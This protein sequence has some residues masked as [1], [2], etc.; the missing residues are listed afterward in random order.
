[1]QVL[2][3]QGRHTTDNFYSKTVVD[4]LNHNPALQSFYS[5]PSTQ[6][7]YSQ[8]IAARKFSAEQRQLLVNVLQQQY[9]SLLQP[10]SPVTKKIQALASPNTYTVT[11]G[12]QIHIYLGP[13]YVVNKILSTIARCNWL[14]QQHPDKTFVPVFW[15][16]TED[17]DFDEISH[18]QLYYK[19][20]HWPQQPNYTGA[21]GR[22]APQ[23][24]NNLEA[25]I[26]EVLNNDEEAKALLDL[27]TEAYT[28]YNTLA[29]AT[30][31]VVHTFF[32]AQGVVVIDADDTQLKQ[33]L[34]PYIHRDVFEGI[35]NK[36]VLET[37]ERLNQEYKAQIHPRE[38]NF[39]YLTQNGRYR[40]AYEDGVYKALDSDITFTKEQIEAEINQHPEN[41]SPNVVMRPMYQELILPNISYIGG[42]AEVNYWLQ[43]KDAFEANQVQFPIIELRKSVIIL[44]P[45]IAEKIQSMGFTVED[46]LLDGKELE[47]RYVEQNSSGAPDYSA[48]YK[49]V[50]EKLEIIKNKALEADNSLKPFLEGEFKKITETFEKLDAKLDKN[51]KRK[52]ENQLKQ[53]E[54]IKTKFFT[55]GQLAERADTILSAPFIGNQQTIDKLVNIFN[56]Q[57][58][59]LIIVIPPLK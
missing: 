46:F 8:A 18:L 41:F 39:F 17:H 59:P 35:N 25:E 13:L 33:V 1:M 32:A 22:I 9:G 27:F 2:A 34:K 45:K 3:A 4:Y 19:Q 30:R 20:Y 31:H 44:N 16:A 11:T 54:N 28:R 38:I 40:L 36:T 51:E 52:F 49:A 57:K 53:I 56:Q 15:M 58:S 55:P 6:E 50:E 48:H 23:T 29:D 5:Y 12:Q 26:R 42:P 24:I 47:T 14:A 21:V 37:T 10:E 43:L 7:G